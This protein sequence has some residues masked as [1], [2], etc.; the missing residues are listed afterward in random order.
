MV[1]F[2]RHRVTEKASSAI[3]WNIFY[4]RKP[5]RPI[6]LLTEDQETYFKHIIDSQGEMRT[7][8]M[9][10]VRTCCFMDLARLWL[11]E[12]NT[13]FWIRWNEYMNILRKPADRKT[14]HSFHFKLS[15]DEIAELRE[16][17]LHLSNFMT[18]TTHWAEEHRRTGYG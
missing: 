17:C 8:F 13:A 10:V 2:Y 7:I 18:S 14:P 16:T 11:A 6:H 1:E 12:S 4:Q 9:N 15:D 5:N 3:E